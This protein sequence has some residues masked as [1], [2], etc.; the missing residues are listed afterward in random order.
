M[1]AATPEERS[2]KHILLD[3]KER[4][5]GVSDLIVK[6]Q[7]GFETDI[8]DFAKVKRLDFNDA[9]RKIFSKY[10][11]ATCLEAQDAYDRFLE[12]AKYFTLFVSFLILLILLFICCGCLTCIQ[13]KRRKRKEDF[14]GH[15]NGEDNLKIDHHW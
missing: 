6:Y 14:F 5:G 15:N 9:E 4:S 8:V 7:K 2:T 10:T 3:Y 13:L 1:A 11:D 12:M